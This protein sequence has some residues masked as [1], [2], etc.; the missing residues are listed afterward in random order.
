LQEEISNI[1]KQTGITILFVTHDISEA[2]KLG[3][4]MLVMDKGEIQQFDTPDEILKNPATEYVSKLVAKERCMCH[5]PEE[6]L[7]DCLYSGA[8]YSSKK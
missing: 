2:L 6:K 4:K 3:T 1:H 5:L 7:K 8:G